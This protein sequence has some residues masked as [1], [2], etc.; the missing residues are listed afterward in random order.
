[1]FKRLILVLVSAG[2]YQQLRSA[3]E[4]RSSGGHDYPSDGRGGVGWKYAGAASHSNT[5][6]VRYLHCGRWGD[7]GSYHTAPELQGDSSCAAT[8]EIFVLKDD[9]K[10]I[11]N[12]FNAVNSIHWY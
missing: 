9:F 10:F 3:R 12:C 7:C 1:M 6:C 4:T 2:G 8:Q 5:Y 11:L